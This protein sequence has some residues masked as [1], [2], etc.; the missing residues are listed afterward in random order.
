MCEWV[1]IALGSGSPLYI[2]DRLKKSTEDVVFM[3]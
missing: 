3:E 1:I 2:R